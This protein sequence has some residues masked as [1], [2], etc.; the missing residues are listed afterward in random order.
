VSYDYYASATFPASAREIQ[1]I[2]EYLN[3]DKFF[4]E[5]TE[6]NGL[7]CVANTMASHGELDITA[8]LNK[9]NVPYDHYR[10]DDHACKVWTDKYR[11]NEFDVLVEAGSES[12]CDEALVKFAKEVIQA[13][14][15]GKTEEVYAMLY[16]A[17]G[18]DIVAIEVIAT[19]FSA[20]KA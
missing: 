17:I 14:E 2:A 3:A 20:Q 13:L 11:V 15:N 12:E 1:A 19:T 6:E 10:R 7:I 9:H 4:G 5:V 8:L 18:A 16:D